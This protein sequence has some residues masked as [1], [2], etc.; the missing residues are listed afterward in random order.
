[1]KVTREIIDIRIGKS[2]TGIVVL[3]PQ[4]ANHTILRQILI[5]IYLNLNSSSLFRFL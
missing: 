5:S 3:Y 2:I 1:M 4:P